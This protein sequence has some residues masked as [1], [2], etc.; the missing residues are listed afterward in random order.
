MFTNV[1]DIFQLIVYKKKIK[2]ITNNIP[3]R[4]SDKESFVCDRGTVPGSENIA[5]KCDTVNSKRNVLKSTMWN[6][7]HKLKCIE[8]NKI[9]YICNLYR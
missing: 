7:A 9:R 2:V 1:I 8:N 5:R 3:C 4:K 6:G